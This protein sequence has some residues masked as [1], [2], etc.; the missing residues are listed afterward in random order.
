VPAPSSSG[1]SDQIFLA[2]L[3]SDLR[4]IP[5]FTKQQLSSDGASLVYRAQQ[6]PIYDGDI[7][8]ANPSQFS[9][10]AGAAGTTFQTLR[11]DYVNLNAANQVYVDYESGFLYWNTAPL[12]GTN[13]VILNCRKV[14]WTNRQMLFGLYSGLRAM[15]PKVFHWYTDTSITMQTNIWEYALPAEFR[16]PRVRIKMVEIQEIPATT[17][18]F[19]VIQGW[20]R[21]GNTSIQIPISQRFSPGS[22]AR[23]TYAGPVASLTDLDAASQELPILYAK[24]V[25]L[26]NAEGPRARM[27]AAPQVQAES[28]NPPNTSM[29]AALQYLQ[30]F[31]RLLD[32]MPMVDPGIVP[33]LPVYAR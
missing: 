7:Y 19:R 15:W 10:Y 29:Q 21:V 6:F 12:S 27:D 14:R 11:G 1:A 16:D 25:L 3:R 20:R 23:V 22:V 31:N 8:Q 33:V 4:D 30:Q 13:N 17:E 5:V 28:A 9:I 26:S 18:R 32:S 24:W 2:Q